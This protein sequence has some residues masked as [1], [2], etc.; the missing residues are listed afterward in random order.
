MKKLFSTC[1][2]AMAIATMSAAELPFTVSPDPSVPLTS[3]LKDITLTAGPD[4]T[5]TNVNDKSAIYV[6]LDGEQYVGTN[7]EV[8]DSETLYIFVK[9]DGIDMPGNYELVIGEGAISINGAPTTETYTINYTFEG[10]GA[11]DN[12]IL[13]PEFPETNT[14]LSQL[15]TFYFEYKTSVYLTVVNADG[16]YLAKDWERAYALEVEPMD[17]FGMQMTVLSED[18]SEY[19][20]V[21][22]PGEYQLCI[23]PRSLAIYD[24]GTSEI[25]SYITEP[26]FFTYIIG[27][28]EVDPTT[29]PYDA[30][31]T[32]GSSVPYLEQIYLEPNQELGYT[33]FVYPD[34]VE[35]LYSN[36]AVFDQEYEFIE[37][38]VN[39]NSSSITITLN[40]PATTKGEYRVM[41][42]PG[43][44]GCAGEGVETYF[45]EGTIE[46]PYTVVGSVDNNYDVPFTVVEPSASDVE[47][48][49]F[50]EFDLNQESGF[51]SFVVNNEDGIYVAKDGDFFMNLSASPEGAI[52]Y[53]DASQ[54]ITE[55]GNYAIVV[56]EGAIGWTNGSETIANPEKYIFN[57]TVKS[58]GGSEEP[59]EAPFTLTPADGST[60]ETL[61]AITLS[62]APEF[63]D[64][65]VESY[66]VYLMDEDYENVMWKYD[67]NGLEASF[68]P[69]D[70]NGNPSPITTPGT[71]TLAIEPGAIQAASDNGEYYTNKDMLMYTF[72]VTGPSQAGPVVYDVIPND[73]KPVEGEIDLANKSFESLTLYFDEQMYAA[74]GAKALITPVGAEDQAISVQIKSNGMPKQLIMFFT[75]FQYNGEYIFTI[76]QGS[77]GDEDW[78]KN[79]ETGHSNPELTYSFTIVGVNDR[80]SNVEY[81]LVPEI[82]PS[83]DYKMFT[84]MF[85]NREIEMAEDAT[86]IFSCTEARY[87][88]TAKFVSVGNGI[89]NVTFEE[90]PAEAGTYVFTIEQGTFG[91]NDFFSS[92]KKSGNANARI[93]KT[94]E[95]KVSGID[96]ISSDNVPEGVYNLM[97]VKVA[98]TLENLPAGIYI[99][100]G[101]KVI[102][103]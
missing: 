87:N 59:V 37:F 97:G 85:D 43:I 39:A 92:E 98:D 89:F 23:E 50:A 34:G 71:Y 38:T 51:T 45:S 28:S 94:F 41:F 68:I 26:I 103:K 42:M 86:A 32:V 22:E 21:T 101:K 55:S 81:N 40:E 48:F 13:S 17:N 102:V 95:I 54:Y 36:M 90:A 14:P 47:A 4:V 61:D 35:E 100:N 2:M 25:I 44:F 70:E 76:P 9:G 19:I 63:E 29:L 57:F 27:K 5:F 99:V 67:E 31:P 24:P 3:A 46:L 66:E 53:L 72:N 1:L 75:E 16:I 79:H 69:V 88:Q 64:Y 15:N 30:N 20:D 96:T 80:G 82:I 74:E 18:A 6:T 58:S 77:F 60:V 33:S 84:V 10:G 11:S 83:S 52:L 8:L 56:E 73:T 7:P 62:F 78:N 65:Y 12:D 49:Y 91:T 93:D